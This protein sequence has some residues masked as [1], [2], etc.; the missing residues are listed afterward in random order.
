MAFRLGIDTGGTYTDAVL[1]DEQLQV[2]ASFK[3]L[4][5]RQDLSIGIERAMQG[6]PQEMLSQIELVSLSTTLTTNSVIEGRGADVCVLLAGYS[7]RQLAKSELHHL[8]AKDAAIVLEGGHD[9]TGDE[10]QPLD[11]VRARQH[12]LKYKDSV[13]AFAIS[14]MFATRNNQHELRLRSIVEELCDKPVACGHELASSLGAPQRAL[15]AVLNARMIPYIHQLVRSV[16]AILKL[17]EIGAP[18]MIVKGDGSLVN[19]Q[20]ALEQP[21]STVLSGPA[22]SVI[23]ACALS[24]LQNAIVIDMGGT[25]TDIAV[26]RNGQPTLST[27][28]AQVGDWRPMIEAVKVF[29]VGLG[30]DSEVQMK[31]AQG[32][33]IGPRRVVP[34]SLLARQYPWVIARL[35]QQ[36]ACYPN[37]RHNKF[38]L[39][40]EGDEQ[41]LSMLTA[42]QLNAWY[43]LQ[44]GPIELDQASETDRELVKSL[45]KLQRL[46]LAIYSGFTP[47]DAAHVLGLSSHLDRE[48]AQLA[49]K[50][51]SNQMRCL[52]GF[53]NWQSD[54]AVGPSQQV[55]EL[56]HEKISQTLIEASLNQL[57]SLSHSRAA[58]LTQLLTRLVLNKDTG[59]SDT[60]A[61]F[62]IDFCSDYP[63]VAVG[64]PASSYYP[65]VAKRLGVKLFLPKHGEVA[66]AVGAVMGSVVQRAQVTISQPSVGIYRLYHRGEPEQFT[67]L[68]EAIAKAE[69][70]ATEEATSMAKVAGASCVEVTITHTRNHVEHP[71]DGELFLDCQVQASATGRPSYRTLKPNSQ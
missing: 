64:A 29:C 58:Q 57:G 27:D 56:L 49:G 7:E 18:L 4:T 51:W 17:R 19:T 67:R 23:G 40:L 14:A 46:G 43:Q 71:I 38:V 48:A 70:L 9:A 1:I 15:T 61:L 28:G 69:V 45:A 32:L 10:I 37:A 68:A 35:K 24:G 13:A 33:T 66:S 47:T 22:A 5:T 52:Y 12:I 50:I 11:E 53:G 60:A 3:S 26:V 20:V 25:T 54:D 63:L 8:V 21:V 34:I 31:G 59:E 42:E 62:N 39:P 55:I 44:Q 36:L 6:L 65:A 2:R 30:G 41:L 16:K